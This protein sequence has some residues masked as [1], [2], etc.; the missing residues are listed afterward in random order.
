MP[1]FRPAWTDL[2]DPQKEN[3]ALP[4]VA[5]DI[6]DLLD[7]LG[8]RGADLQ[9]DGE[10]LAVWVR[11]AGW[12]YGLRAAFREPRVKAIV[13]YSPRLASALYRSRWVVVPTWGRRLAGQRPAPHRI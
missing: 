7:V 8:S 10:S 11:S 13:A 2:E 5:Q 3:A 12:S 1:D 4:A 9:I 6:D